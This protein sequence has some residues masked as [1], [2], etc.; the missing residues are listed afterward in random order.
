MT[1]STLRNG[2]TRQGDLI[3]I[4]IADG[5]I[6]ALRSA[7]ET[8]VLAADTDLAG[9]VVLPLLVNGHAHLDKTFLGADWQPHLPGDGVRERIEL[10]KQLRTDLADS[11][12]DRE[13]LLVQRMIEFGTG[14]LRAHVDIDTGIGLAGFERMLRLREELRGAIDLQVVA[15]PQ[16]GI[17]KDPGTE[18]LLAEAIRLGADLVGGLDPLGIDGD[19]DG[20]LDAVF[21]LADR[22]GAGI[23]IHLHGVGPEALS[24]YRAIIERTRALGLAG[25]VTLSHAYGLGELSP[26]ERD[27]IFGAFA[28]LGISVMTNGPAGSMPPVHALIERGVPV[29]AGS[30]NVRDA[31]WPFGSGDVLD[32]ARNIAYQQGFR[33]DA[34]LGLALE[35]ATD[36]AAAVLG[37]EGYGI[38][39]GA[40]AN[41]LVLGAATAAEALADPPVDRD[42]MRGGEW[43]SHRRLET[44]TL[45]F[46]PGVPVRS[47][48]TLS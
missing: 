26:H 38:A 35:L 39:V 17:L 31:W 14:A 27:E 19:L 10:E 29:F 43:I 45:L 46:P 13:R 21:G 5:V 9:R 34:D 48:P 18:S 41:L 12:A 6:A 28:E 20:H 37:I 1:S 30:D 32:V 44:D 33:S 25:R 8:P 22:G 11:A 47:V 3:D 36:R 4:E 16:S 23:D 42:V 7:T 2:R 40:P 24:E 15:F